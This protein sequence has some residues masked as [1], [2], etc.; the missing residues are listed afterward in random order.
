MIKKIVQ[1]K[2][3]SD[4]SNNKVFSIVTYTVLF[5]VS[6]VM[7][8]LNIITSK[9]FLTVATGIF[10]LL[11]AINVLLALKDGI[12]TSI[13][14]FLFAV[15]V[16]CLFTFF[17]VSGNPDGF[18]AIW[19]CMLPSIGM[20]FFNRR[21]GS[22]LCIAMLFIL[23]FFLWL[24][25]G[26]TLLM[27]DYTSTFKMRFPVLFVAFHILA[28]FLETLRHNAYEETKRIQE[29]YKELSIRDQLTRVFN[30]QG[31]YSAL[32][33]DERYTGAEN[34]GVAIFDIDNFKSINDKYGHNAGDIV[35]V[36]FAEILK[37]NLNAIICRWG[38]EEFVV[39]FC[40]DTIK[41]SDF[42]NVI[43]NFENHE[44]ISG[45]NR[46]NVTASVGVYTES[47]FDISRIES[48]VSNA[49]EALYHAK[50]TGKNKVVY[51]S[52]LNEKS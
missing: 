24:P 16:L 40:S 5:T 43:K 42:N 2:I 27:Y 22:L 47:G 12:T 44:F 39:V 15:E 51:Y 37:L 38:G 25:Y 10:A 29:H 35:L 17:L 32:E 36:K 20:T 49:D 46:F 18:S 7:T 23:I 34:I 30:R 48:L 28:F 41:Q 6:L 45:E 1:N 33:K 3:I 50:N 21:R 19:I 26:Q 13:A 52:D 8:V 14:K 11:C 4:I 31:M 9:G